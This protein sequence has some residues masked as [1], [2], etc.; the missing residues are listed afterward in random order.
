MLKKT[1]RRKELGEKKHKTAE[2]GE[3]KLDAP[4]PNRERLQKKLWVAVNSPNVN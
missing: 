3:W 4:T 2:L 1:R